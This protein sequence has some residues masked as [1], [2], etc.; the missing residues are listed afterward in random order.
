MT[1]LAAVANYSYLDAIGTFP[2]SLAIRQ[3]VRV[4]LIED[5]RSDVFM[6]SRML[7]DAAHPNAFEMVDAP[8]LSDALELL[9]TQHFDIILLDLNLLD[10]DGV[11]SVAA[12]HAEAPHT[13]IIVHSGTHDP[14]M[15]R[16]ALMCGARHYLVKGRESAFSLRFMIGQA[17]KAK[18]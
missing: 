11:A 5:N 8:R 2:N 1:Q 12:L 17:L 6:V 4:L 13:P 10:M 18:A 3:A 15:R 14:Q 7:R 9:D 16:E